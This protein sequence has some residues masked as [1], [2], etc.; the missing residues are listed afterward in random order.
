MEALILPLGVLSAKAETSSE[1]A[2]NLRSLLSSFRSAHDDLDEMAFLSKKALLYEK[3]AKART[4][5][6]ITEGR[7]VGFFSIAIKSIELCGVSKTLRKKLLA[8]ESKDANTTAF[9]IGH[10]ARSADAPEGFGARILDFAINYILKAREI[11]GGRLAYLD[12]KDNERLRNYYEKKGFH[13][14]RTAPNT[15]LLQYFIAL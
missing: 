6:V 11:V 5:L 13:F 12:C 1:Q 14:L 7:F 3:L 2:E 8:G 4:Y 9:L 10:L 15:Q